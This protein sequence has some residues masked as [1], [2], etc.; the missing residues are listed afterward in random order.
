MK[1]FIDQDLSAGAAEI[2][3]SRGLDGVHAREVGLSKADDVAI[4]E[5]CRA[6]GRVVVTADADFHAHLAL[7][8]SRDPSVIRIRVEGLRDSALA[9][10]IMRAVDALRADLASGCAASITRT[11]IRVHLLP[12]TGSE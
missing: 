1:L 10:L 9:D 5:W 12:L 11:S 6:E 7:S 4:M 8:A 3:R 2:L